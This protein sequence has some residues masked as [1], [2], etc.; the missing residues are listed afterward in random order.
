MDEELIRRNYMFKRFVTFTPVTGIYKKM[1]Q[2]Y[3]KWNE[4]ADMSRPIELDGEYY[5]ILRITG[6]INRLGT[7][8]MV[9]CHEDGQLIK[10]ENLSRECVNV[11]LYLDVFQENSGTIIIN[12][13]ADTDIK[14]NEFIVEF[15]KMYENVAPKLTEEEREAMRHH[16]YYYEEV[17]RF[18]KIVA[19][20]TSRLRPYIQPIKKNKIEVYS[21]SLINKLE[22]D[23][24]QWDTN[25]GYVEALM[26]ENGL[27]ARDTVRKILK[28][29]NY[30]PYFPNRKI[31]K[32]M[33]SEMNEAHRASNGLIQDGKGR[34]ERE[35]KWTNPN[36]G[37]FTIEK[38]L[39]DLWNQNNSEVIKKANAN[40]FITAY[41]LFS[42]TCIYA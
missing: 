34:W 10:D 30:Q 19:R 4:L 16:L 41:W 12:S 8:K 15:K 21:A 33:I 40:E 26:I 2:P 36:K 42:P 17:R 35:V 37:R 3:K 38:Y 31:I 39:N 23:L 11:F 29:K 13:K 25:R 20:A 14:L 24:A 18:M 9:M 6:L 27:K 7:R 5:R 1:I 32:K 22:K 28:N